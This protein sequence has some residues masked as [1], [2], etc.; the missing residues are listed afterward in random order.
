MSTRILHFSAYFFLCKSS[1]DSQSYESQE[2]SDSA[3]DELVEKVIEDD[4]SLY[5]LEDQLVDYVVDMDGTK[6]Y[7]TVI[8]SYVS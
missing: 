6:E 8:G 5:P 4:P 1:A 3:I 2:P 7:H